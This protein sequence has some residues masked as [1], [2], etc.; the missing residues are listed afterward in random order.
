M[1]S[2]LRQM[3]RGVQWHFNGVP[4]VNPDKDERSVGSKLGAIAPAYPAH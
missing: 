2:G 4:V 1:A 3:V